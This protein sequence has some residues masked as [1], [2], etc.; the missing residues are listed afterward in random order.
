MWVH[1]TT[2]LHPA[3]VFATD[4]APKLKPVPDEAF[5]IPTITCRSTEKRFVIRAEK[6]FATAA[7]SAQAGASDSDPTTPCNR[8]NLDDLDIELPAH[9]SSA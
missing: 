2:R 3:E 5:D 4:E 9:T 8:I 7:L 1:G 6:S